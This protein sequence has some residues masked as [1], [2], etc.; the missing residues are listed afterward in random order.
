MPGSKKGSD[1]PFLVIF[2]TRYLKYPEL[3]PARRGGERRGAHQATI[4]FAGGPYL[5]RG[6]DSEQLARV[7]GHFGDQCSRSDPPPAPAVAIEV[8]RAAAGDFLPPLLDG[9]PYSFDMDHQPSEI[10]IAGWG[11]MARIDWTPGLAGAL[12][13]PHTAG[14][15]RIEPVENYFRALVAYRL[16]DLRG[17]LL[18]SAGVVRGGGAYLFIG[19]SGA[20]KTTVS[21]ISL[22]AGLAVLS[23]DL[24]A[25]VKEE[26]GILVEKLPFSGELGMTRT[27]SNRYPAQVLCRLEQGSGNRLRPMSRAEILA[28]LVACSPFANTDPHRF[29]QLLENLE[30]LTEQVRAY[31]LT[32]TPDARFW[33][34]LAGEEPIPL[35]MTG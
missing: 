22:E 1:T 3:F 23:D 20:G 18:H 28:A 9:T 6:L 21:R 33:E 13:L 27:R 2:G 12:W 35:P 24:N 25:L 26:E 8:Y 5:F 10:R 31:R 30:E 14:P 17:A 19:P 34:L 16:L 11:F 15:F 29:G 32:F 7:R 4:E